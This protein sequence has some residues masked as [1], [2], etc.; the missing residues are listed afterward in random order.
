MHWHDDIAASDVT[1]TRERLKACDILQVD[2]IETGWGQFVASVKRRD[3]VFDLYIRQSGI[4]DWNMENMTV[5]VDK[6][7]AP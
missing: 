2:R 3:D 1:V 6:E 7:S 4:L 5:P